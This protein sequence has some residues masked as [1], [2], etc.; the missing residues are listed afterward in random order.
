VV[1]PRDC[2]RTGTGAPYPRNRRTGVDDDPAVGDPAR[3]RQRRK[4]LADLLRRQVRSKLTQQRD[5][6]GDMRGPQR[7]IR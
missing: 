3:L 5:Q 1:T 4:R 6:P 7:M 2:A